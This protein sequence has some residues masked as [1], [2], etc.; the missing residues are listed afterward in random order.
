MPRRAII[1][2]HV[3]HRNNALRNNNND[4]RY[5]LIHMRDHLFH[6]AFVRIAII[7]A[8]VFSGR[9]RKII[10]FIILTSVS[11]NNVI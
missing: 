5:P 8:T 7:Y 10:E 1:Q 4:V 2:F 11:I 6:V 9:A 3:L